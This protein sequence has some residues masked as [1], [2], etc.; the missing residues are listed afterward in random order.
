MDIGFTFRL[1]LGLDRVNRGWS[2]LNAE[3]CH[4]KHRCDED[5]HQR[6]HIM[7]RY[8]QKHVSKVLVIVVVV[9]KY[10]RCDDDQRQL[11]WGLRDARLRT[12]RVRLLSD[13]VLR[14]C[15]SSRW[16]IAIVVT[17]Y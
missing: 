4:Q 17:M 13:L 5:V 3:I 14:L 2:Y 15:S 8:V 12:E 1:R 11:K 6:E 9:E 10:D 16:K 7:K